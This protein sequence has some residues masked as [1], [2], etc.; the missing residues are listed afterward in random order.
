MEKK[1]RSCL[2]QSVSVGSFLWPAAFKLSWNT[3]HMKHEVVR[4]DGGVGGAIQK[5]PEAGSSA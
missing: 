2:G 5:R 1:G 4:N 3:V